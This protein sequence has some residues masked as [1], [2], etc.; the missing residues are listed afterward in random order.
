ML[1]VTE[2]AIG[3]ALASLGFVGKEARPAI[4]RQMQ[5]RDATLTE[6]AE[7]AVD[8]TLADDEWAGLACVSQTVILGANGGALR[9]A[10]REV[11]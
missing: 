1:E 9:R 3:T 2:V 10:Q 6:V 7:L 5:V 8:T 11:F 4:S